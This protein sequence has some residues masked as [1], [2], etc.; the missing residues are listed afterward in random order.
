MVYIMLTNPGHG[1]CD[2]K[3]ASI[4]FSFSG[5]RNLG[6]INFFWYDLCII[7]QLKMEHEK[8]KKVGS[9]SGRK[10]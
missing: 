7:C 9:V 1:P 4:F 10:E 8:K 6:S 3:A 2:H 5:K